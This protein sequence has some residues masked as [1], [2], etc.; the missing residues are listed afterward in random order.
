MPK[1]SAPMAAPSTD[2]NPPVSRQPPTTAAMMY[3]NS[4]P[5]PWF[6]CTLANR[7]RLQEPT[8]QPAKAVPMNSRILV[9][10][11]GTPTARALGSEPPTA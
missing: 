11:A 2:P 5:T 3:W 6:A 1:I 7:S 9:R 8:I 4:S 10:A